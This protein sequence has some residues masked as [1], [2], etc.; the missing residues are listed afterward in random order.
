VT[1]TFTTLGCAVAGGSLTGG[2][3]AVG[4]ETADADAEADADGGGATAG[5]EERGG[6][7]I[8]GPALRGGEDRLL[9][10][11]SNTMTSTTAPTAPSGGNNRRIVTEAGSPAR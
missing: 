11:S 10:T 2:A 7:E 8:A 9:S 3:G 4:V 5:V 6:T 1:A